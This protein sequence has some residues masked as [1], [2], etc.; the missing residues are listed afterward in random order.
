LFGLGNIK[1][2]KFERK[3][4]R[5]NCIIMKKKFSFQIGEENEEKIYS[6]SL[7]KMANRLI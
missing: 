2:K 5:E 7:V 4:I 1:K 6:W 3:N